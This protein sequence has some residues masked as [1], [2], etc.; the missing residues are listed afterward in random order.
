MMNQK[1][2]HSIGGLFLVIG[3]LAMTAN[4]TAETMS[5]RPNVNIN[6][7]SSYQGEEA[8]AIDTTNPNR[9][10]PWSNDLNARNSAGYS[11]NG[12]A[13]WTSR[14][15]GSDGWPAVGMIRLARSIVLEIFSEPRSIRRS[16]SAGL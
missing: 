13:S 11:T 16:A 15:T 7:Q 1:R 8:I 9:L 6:R 2:F 14:F 4:V 5:V 12:G 10:F 3:L